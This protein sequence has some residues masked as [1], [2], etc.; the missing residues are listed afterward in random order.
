LMKQC[1]QFRVH[2]STA[3]T[4]WV[5]QPSTSRAYVFRA[6]AIHVWHHA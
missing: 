5:P 4:Q 2:L 3:V 1:G 6:A